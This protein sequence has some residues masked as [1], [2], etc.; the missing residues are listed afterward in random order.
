MI[1]DLQSKGKTIN[2][3]E[4]LQIIYS[5]LGD[6]KSKEGLLKIFQLYD[7]DQAGFIDFQKIKRVCR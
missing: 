4:F 5:K 6:T 2:F 7:N 1:K 3:D